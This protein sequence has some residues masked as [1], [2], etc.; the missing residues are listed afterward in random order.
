MLI[1][2]QVKWCCGNCDNE[3]QA[4]KE[5]NAI[6]GQKAASV[7]YGPRGGLEFVQRR[8]SYAEATVP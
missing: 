4:D 6:R 7:L 8:G 3:R 5:L 1:W 2:S